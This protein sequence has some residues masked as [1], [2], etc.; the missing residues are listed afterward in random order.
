MIL[1]DVYGNHYN[2]NLL[3]ADQFARAGYYVLIPDILKGDDHTEGASLQDWFPKHTPDITAPIVNGFLSQA[4]ASGKFD[5]IGVVGY[6]FGAKY[7]IQQIANGK[8]ASAGAV[9]HP[10]LVTIEEVAAVTK[11]LIISAAEVD[12]VF[13]AELRHQT[14]AK[15]QEVGATYQLDLFSKVSHGYA[16]RGDVSVP[17]VRYAK[18]KTLRDQVEWFNL[19]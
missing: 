19:F 5:F 17:L 4:H 3:V 7:A 16:I 2:N 1:T 6:C 11:P 12:P 13:S 14:E 15:L 10:S 18:E 8:Y 9:A